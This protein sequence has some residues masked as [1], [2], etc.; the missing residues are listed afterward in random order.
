M[1]ENMVHVKPITKTNWL[2]SGHD[3]EIRYTGC[4]EFLSVQMD[5]MTRCLNTGLDE[6]EEKELEAKLNLKP[7]TLSRFNFSY[8]GD[9][10]RSI[11]IG[12]DGI[13]LN[14]N[15]PK[16]YI[17]YKNLLVHSDVANSETEK[18]DSPRYKYVI[19]SVEQ[20]AKVENEKAKIKRKAYRLFDKMSQSEMTGF[21][22][23]IG[24]RPDS[25]SSPDFLESQINKVIE[26]RPED[27]IDIVED[28]DFKMKVFISDC[29]NARILQKSGSKYSLTGG[30]VI[31]IDLDSTVKYLSDPNNQDVYKN[32]KVKIKAI[33]V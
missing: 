28:K 25:S 8:W 1:N 11:V 19:T 2:P 14:L 13:R 27:F 26:N 5:P 21:L 30:D 18:F 3:G 32:L 6:S 15:N 17:I 7:G 22:K 12:K 31:G 9:F 23:M 33:E 16:D 10:R 29:V 4:A 20:E 24:K